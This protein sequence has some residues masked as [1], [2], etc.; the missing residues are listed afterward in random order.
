MLPRIPVVLMLS[1]LALATD[2]LAAAAAPQET[3]VHQR[4]ADLRLIPSAQAT[5]DPKEKTRPQAAPDTIRAEAAGEA[6][7]PPAPAGPEQ[8]VQSLHS[9]LI[10]AMKGGKQMGFDGRYKLLAPVVDRDFDLT[11]VARLSLGSKW[12]DLTKQQREQ[13]V[14]AL[15]RYSIASYAA[16]FDS[17]DGGRFKPESTN[18]PQRGVETVS[19]RFTSKGSA[20]EHQFNYLLHETQS[21]W[22]IINVVVDG[23]SDLSLKRSQYT[24]IMQTEGFDT[25]LSKLNASAN[26]LAAGGGGEIQAE[27]AGRPLADDAGSNA[28]AM[29]PGQAGS[30]AS[31]PAPKKALRGSTSA[32]T[33]GSHAGP[34]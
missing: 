16:E 6:A 34:D 15:R 3:N 10:N 25:L 24:R 33:Q 18:S 13:F 28:G 19:T 23:V 2:W 20:K 4:P 22:R 29:D 21:G 31:Q 5:A 32:P 26:R 27:M 30:T 8:V 14:Q 11:Y 17:Y 7:D 1:A 12:G 9:A